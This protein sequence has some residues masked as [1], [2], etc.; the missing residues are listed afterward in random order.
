[1]S[2]IYQ[3]F[4]ELRVEFFISVRINLCPTACKGERIEPDRWGFNPIKYSRELT[5]Y[6]S[7]N[8]DVIFPPSSEHLLKEVYKSLSSLSLGISVLTHFE[9]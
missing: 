6:C 3:P 8:A 4:E 9:R 1:M 5:E 2:Y 7:K